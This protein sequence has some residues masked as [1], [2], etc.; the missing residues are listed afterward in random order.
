M[1]EASSSSEAKA[2]QQ[3]TGGWRGADTSGIPVDVPADGEPA[4]DDRQGGRDAPIN[5]GQ[6]GDPTAEKD[7]DDWVTGDEAATGAQISY[8]ETLCRRVGRSVPER[9]TK[10][11][12]SRLID[13]LQAE[14]GQRP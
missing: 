5:T 8:L 14:S 13:E 2:D 6:P 1:T 4:A 11:D 10:A 9:L 3:G 7:P 12:A